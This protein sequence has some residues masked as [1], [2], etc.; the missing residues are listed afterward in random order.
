[1]YI[2]IHT[3]NSNYICIYT[4]STA[5]SPSVNKR[6]QVHACSLYLCFAGQNGRWCAFCLKWVGEFFVVSGGVA[7]DNDV[8]VRLRECVMLR[9]DTLSVIIA[10]SKLQKPLT[11]EE[12]QIPPR[13][14]FKP[15]QQYRL[16]KL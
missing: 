3:Y 15:E 4:H 8:H 5:Y 11:S 9:S 6:K 7:W 2:Y 16:H 13:E 10:M 12:L 14:Y 1:M